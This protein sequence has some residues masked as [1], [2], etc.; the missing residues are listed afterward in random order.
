MLETAALEMYEVL[1]DI[2]P[3]HDMKFEEGKSVY[4]E[5]ILLSVAVVLLA[6]SFSGILGF[7]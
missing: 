7:P 3:W 1:I 5:M 4:L 6:F 2:Y